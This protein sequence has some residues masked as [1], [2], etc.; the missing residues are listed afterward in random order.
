MAAIYAQCIMVDNLQTTDIL[1]YITMVQIYS[2][3]VALLIYMEQKYYL[4]KNIH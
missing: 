4:K 1:D 2:L 3:K